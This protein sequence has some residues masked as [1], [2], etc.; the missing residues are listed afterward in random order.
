MLPS[1]P[2]RSTLRVCMQDTTGQIWAAGTLH[3]DFV[4]GADCDP[5]WIP[6]EDGGSNVGELLVQVR[7]N[8]QLPSAG[9]TCCGLV[10]ACTWDSTGLSN[11]SQS[12]SDKCR[13]LLSAGAAAV[14]ARSCK[15]AAER[16]KLLSIRRR[17]RTVHQHLRFL[18]ENCVAVSGVVLWCCIGPL[19]M[20]DVGY[21]LLAFLLGGVS[22]PERSLNSMVCIFACIEGQQQVR[23]SATPYLV[24]HDLAMSPE[25]TMSRWVCSGCSPC[26]GWSRCIAAVREVWSFRSLHED[27]CLV[28][29][30]STTN[31]QWRNCRQPDTSDKK[32]SDDEQ[33]EICEEMALRIIH[34][35]VQGHKG[36][37]PR[38]QPR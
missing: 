35:C 33:H 36:T 8:G 18:H 20:V 15:G 9:A 14:A 10:R 19:P 38:T 5:K 3:G 21:Y 29:V 30:C 7:P 2:G 34:V 26:W 17:A 23:T 6:L 27:A 24:R 16:G 22:A 32:K 4:G 1:R 13:L 12:I 37:A 25:F 31:M 28:P 11:D